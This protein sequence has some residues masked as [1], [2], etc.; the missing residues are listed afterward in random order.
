MDIKVTNARYK[1]V[2]SGEAAYDGGGGYSVVFVDHIYL[3]YYKLYC[4]IRESS[5]L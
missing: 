1:Q 5:R 4:K 2:C 3:Y